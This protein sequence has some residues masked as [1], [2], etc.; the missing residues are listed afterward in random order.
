MS[1]LILNFLI[2]VIVDIVVSDHY[3][4][5]HSLSGGNWTFF[6]FCLNFVLIIIPVFLDAIAYKINVSTFIMT[7][8]CKLLSS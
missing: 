2:A 5:T 8:L 1:F 7:K 4:G 6:V 3:W